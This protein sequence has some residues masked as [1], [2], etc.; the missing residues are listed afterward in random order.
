MTGVVGVSCARHGCFVPNGLVDLFKGEQ[1]K[2]VD[3][4]FLKSLKTTN[5]DVDQG[6]ILIYDIACQYFV[7]LQDRIGHLLPPGL[8]IDRGIGAFHVHGHKDQCFHRFATSFIP[9]AGVVAGEMESQWATMNTISPVVRTATI[10]H[11]AEVLDDHATDW[12]YK[13]MLGLRAYLLFSF[14]HV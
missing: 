3:W 6:V 8:V 10:A 1:Q 12:N 2:N 7:H 9:H 14:T 4:A 13:K 11:R 5:V